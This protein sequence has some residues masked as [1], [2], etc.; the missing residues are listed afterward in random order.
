LVTFETNA[1]GEIDRLR[2]PLEPAL[3]PIVFTRSGPAG[4]AP[5]GS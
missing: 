2:L 5:N 4:V 3:A 1:K